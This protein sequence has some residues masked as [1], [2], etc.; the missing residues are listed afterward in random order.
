M[1]MT[2]ATLLEIIP[3]AYKC[4]I[5]GLPQRINGPINLSISTEK[6]YQIRDS[7]LDPND[8]ELE[9][10]S[11]MHLDCLKICNSELEK[12]DSLADDFCASYL[13]ALKPTF[14]GG[15]ASQ[16]SLSVV[17]AEMPGSNMGAG[18]MMMGM[19]S[20]LITS[21]MMPSSPLYPGALPSGSQSPTTAAKKRK[22]NLPKSATNLLKKWL[23]DHMF[24][25][26]PTEEE[27]AALCSSTGLSVSQINNWFINARR[28]ILKPMVEGVRQQ[29][30]QPTT[31]LTGS[32]EVSPGMN[33]PSNP[34]RAKKENS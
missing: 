9:D 23:F 31:P 2:E 24:H 28:R 14:L 8:P 15:N 1:T 4:E 12:M 19:S 29:Q 13:E 20:P 5:T 25:P 18:V 30:Q 34:K 7:Y 3:V 6:L 26:Y 11:M 27:K 33:S 32:I 10:F 21:P 17:S 16:S 22:G